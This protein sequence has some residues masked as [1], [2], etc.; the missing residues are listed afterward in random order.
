MSN[1]L[2]LLAIISL[3]GLTSCQRWD[4]EQVPDSEKFL[5]VHTEQFKPRAFRQQYFD[6]TPSGN[7]SYSQGF[8]DGC[9][10][11]TS[12]IGSGLARIKGPKIDGYRL[13][14]DPWYLRGFQDASTYCTFNLD[15][16]T[17]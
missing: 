15:W 6:H 11:A 7:D 2:L 10:T 17:H 3:M 9:Q 12:A 16:E 1:R 13:S 5:G 8:K 4:R 14:S